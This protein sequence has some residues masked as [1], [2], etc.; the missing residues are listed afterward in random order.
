M[1]LFVVVRKVEIGVGVFWYMF[2]VYRWNGIR[3]SLK[4][5]LIIIRLKFV[6]NSGLLSIL[7]LRFLFNVIND[8]LL[9]CV[10]I[11]VI[12]NSRKEDVVVE[13]MVYLILV[14]SECFWWKV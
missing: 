4:L 13:R 1:I 6:S 9:D 11:S 12:L 2:G 3:E 10:Y 7:L 8:R 14:F 5:R